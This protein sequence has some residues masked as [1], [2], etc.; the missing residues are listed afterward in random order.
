MTVSDTADSRFRLPD[1]RAPQ[2]PDLTWLRATG[3]LISRQAS[4]E[5]FGAPGYVWTLSRP[6]ANGFACSPRDFRPPDSAVGRSTASGRFVIA[7]SVVDVG[8]SGDIWDRPCPTRRFAVELHRFNWLP[9]LMAAGDRA[10]R[11][12]LRL[13]LAWAEVFGKWNAFSWGPETLPRR[14]INLA[15]WGRRI[16]AST[17]EADRARLADLLARQARHLSRLGARAHEAE[18]A[19]AQVLAGAALDEAAGGPILRKGLALLRKALPRTV[20]ADGCHASRNPE[21]GLELLFDLLSVDDALLQIGEEPPQEVRRAIDRLTAGLRSLT[22]PDGRLA[23]FQG[24]EML[25]PQRVAAARAHDDTG[26]P[27]GAERL[28]AGGYERLDGQMMHIILDAGAPAA[29]AFPQTACAQPAALE[30]VCGR[31][32]L[33]TN[34]GWSE[35]A[36][37]RQGFRLTPAASTLSLGEGSIGEILS[38]RMERILGPRLKVPPMQ[39]TVSREAGEGAILVE[40]G[41][42]GWVPDYGLRHERR[43]YL[44]QRL[45]EVRGEERLVPTGPAV[46]ALAAPYAVRF[47]LQ[48]GATASMARDRRSVILRGE[49]GRGW[50]FRSDAADVAIEPSACFE[51]GLTRRSVQIVLRGSVRTDAESRV[52]WKLEPAGATE[53]PA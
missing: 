14:V 39:V 13:I 10:P 31:D 49:S 12:A 22:L 44:D 6:R 47:F 34:S 26:S 23:A 42:D 7:G 46:N 33:I 4:A 36:H 16:G 11:E 1:L 43:L 51:N 38:G 18:F 29:S 8:S 41:H 45:D 19:C 24:G 52:R 50:F 35:R 20:L 9:D 2:M 53:T 30:I 3:R 37:D 28:M 27:A 48:P 21:A 25:T 32:R 15:C 17:S 40:T 5:L